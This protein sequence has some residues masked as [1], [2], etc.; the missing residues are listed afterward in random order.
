MDTHAIHVI[1]GL[2]LASLLPSSESVQISRGS[3]SSGVTFQLQEP[4]RLSWTNWE[5]GLR[6]PAAPGLNHIASVTLSPG[7]IY[8]TDFIGVY[9]LSVGVP[10]GSTINAITMTLLGQGYRTAPTLFGIV[11]LKND[12][13]KLT[14]VKQHMFQSDPVWPST[15]STAVV[16]QITSGNFSVT[17][18][19][20]PGFG[21][22][23]QFTA[24]PDGTT[25]GAG[26]MVMTLDYTLPPPTPTTQE[27]T[28][29]PLTTQALSTAA[30]TTQ[31]LTTQSLTTQPL[32]T[33]DLTTQPLT[34]K[35]LTT[36]AFTTKTF[37]TQHLT[38]LALTTLAQTSSDTTTGDAFS[39][40]SSEEQRSAG[41][42][43]G[44]ILGGIAA[45]AL[46]LVGGLFLWRYWTRRGV[47]S[48]KFKEMSSDLPS[49]A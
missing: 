26:C 13:D 45:L 38:T 36:Q 19:N 24:P 6:C 20:S 22:A 21:I 44:G 27:L 9:D 31:P 15:Y 46:V 42:I 2:L 34:T 30:L 33:Q 23:V 47:T 11:L 25:F 43:V 35:S 29:Q 5:T 37:T 12:T 4:N 1:F 18:I 32:T 8:S 49:E 39:E 3:G 16:A 7:P 17:D 40:E 14:L 28:T 10:E 41:K 48:F